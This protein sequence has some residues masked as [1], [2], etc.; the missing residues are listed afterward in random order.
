MAK[1]RLTDPH[2]TSA[3]KYRSLTSSPH[4]EHGLER[5]SHAVY[6]PTPHHSHCCPQHPPPSPQGAQRER[7]LRFA[8]FGGV[9]GRQPRC[10]MMGGVKTAAPPPVRPNPS[11]GHGCPRSPS[12]T[13]RAWGG[14]RPALPRAGLAPRVRPR[15][16]GPWRPRRGS[17]RWSRARTGAEGRCPC[18]QRAGSVVP[19]RTVPDRRAAPSS[20]GARGIRPSSHRRR[21]LLRAPERQRRKPTVKVHAGS[22]SRPPPGPRRSHR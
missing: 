7:R 14:R 18:R 22:A 20:G 21:R 17:G 13:T 10:E 1:Q 19:P 5:T 15:I 11:S 4:Q 9:R 2:I 8:Q 16:P 6:L 12:R 3:G